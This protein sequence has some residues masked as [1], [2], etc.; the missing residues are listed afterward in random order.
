MSIIYY[1]TNITK[2][3]HIIQ[4]HILERKIIMY[5]LDETKIMEKLHL[6]ELNHKQ[7]KIIYDYE[8]K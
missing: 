2:I 7:L 8:K 1:N 6:K 5:L 4:K 3:G